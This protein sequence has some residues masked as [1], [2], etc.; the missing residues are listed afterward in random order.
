MRNSLLVI[1][2]IILCAGCKPTAP[3]RPVFHGSAVVDTALVNAMAFNQKMADEADLLLTRY[4]KQ[5][6]VMT[7]DNYWIRGLHSQDSTWQEGEFISYEAALY[8]LE[9]SLIANHQGHT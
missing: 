9:D 2:I 6:Y 3:Q 1:F 8:T 5:G 7:E 4:A